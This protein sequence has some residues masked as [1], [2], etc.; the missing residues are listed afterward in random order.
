MNTSF[1]QPKLESRW[2]TYLKGLGW[3]A[4]ATVVWIF[5][6]LFLFPK[7]RQIWMEAGAVDGRIGANNFIQFSNSALALSGFL[8]DHLILFLAAIV[9]V[10]VL[11]ERRNRWWP[12]YR[13]LSIGAAAFLINCTVLIL[14]TVMLISALLVAPALMG[15]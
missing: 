8:A 6:C 12:N 10:F 15:R 13:R 11:L 9:A 3:M 5:S 2:I 4:P 7:L 14:M 1:A